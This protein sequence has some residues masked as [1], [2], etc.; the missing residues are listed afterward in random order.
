VV[1]NS[2]ATT[3]TGILISTAS[4]GI[5]GGT[6][7]IILATGSA[8]GGAGMG[9]VYVSGSTLSSSVTTGTLVVDGGLGVGSALNVGGSISGSSITTTATGAITMGYAGLNTISSGSNAMTL[10]NSST[11]SGTTTNA[12]AINLTSS[13]TGGNIVISSAY[14]GTSNG[15][16]FFS[17]TGVPSATGNVAF[18]FQLVGTS[19]NYSYISS[20][21]GTF[22]PPSDEKLKK[23]IEECTLGIDFISKI[24]PK[25]YHMTSQPDDD[26]KNHGFV[27]Q[28]IEKVCLEH[29]LNPQ[30]IVTKPR[31]EEDSYHLDYTQLIAPMVKAIQEQQKMINEMRAEL[32]KLKQ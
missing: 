26:L 29:N 31:S 19:S 5:V 15:A 23:N 1:I 30:S 12:G 24:E 32:D 3:T 2:Q 27:A 16:I 4:T 20:S 21:N 14:T 10:T 18:R 13:A 9:T 22:N 28:Q 8:T 11:A 6:P 17:A 7:A 25:T